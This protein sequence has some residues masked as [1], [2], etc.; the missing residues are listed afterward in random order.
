MRCPARAKAGPAAAAGFAGGGSETILFVED[1]DAVRR[2][3]L[4]M[5]RKAGYQVIEARSAEEA[6]PLAREHG[7]RIRL[8]LSDVMMPGM[9]GPELARRLVAEMPGL[10]VLFISGY[11]DEVLEQK[12]VLGKG[13]QLLMKPFTSDALA[14]KVREVLDSAQ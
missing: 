12:G 8:L 9:N 13:V 5:L 2:F 14:Q 3:T 6:I 1:N 7:S 4:R 11:P 10:K